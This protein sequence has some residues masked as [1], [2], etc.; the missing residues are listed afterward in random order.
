MLKKEL[1]KMY[2]EKRRGLAP[3]DRAA[4][5]EAIAEGFF[6]SFDIAAAAFVHCFLSIE[7][8]AEIDTSP[9]FDRI[10]SEFPRTRMV[11]P[12]VDVEKS[13]LEHLQITR[14][15][16]LFESDW[17][18]SEPVSD[19]FVEASQIDIVLVPLLVV[20]RRGFRVGYG[21]GLYDKFLVNCRR[22]CKKI[23]L[24]LFPPIEK[25]DDTNENDVR[26]D[27]CLT[28]DSLIKF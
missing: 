15:T 24:S 17:S 20:D 23:G 1:R 5:S 25:I 13:A 21:K 19:D 14:S 6:A 2:L 12:R 28:P 16:P 18:I 26:L 11:V 22:D 27:Y 7:K 3:G 8:F 9:I 10:W 4:M